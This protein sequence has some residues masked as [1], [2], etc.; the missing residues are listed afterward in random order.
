MKLTLGEFLQ[1]VFGDWRRNPESET[2]F[3]ETR[4]EKRSE[5]LYDV[6]FCKICVNNSTT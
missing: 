5:K 3:V 2:L 6:F 4:T 1:A